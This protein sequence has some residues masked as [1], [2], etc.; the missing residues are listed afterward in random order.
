MLDSLDKVSDERIK[1][2]E[3]IKRDK[4]MASRAYNKRVKKKIISGR[5]PCLKDDFAYWV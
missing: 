1:A 5:R 2:L 3:E 4:L